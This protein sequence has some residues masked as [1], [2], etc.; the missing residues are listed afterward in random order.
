MGKSL[1]EV[2]YYSFC[3][4]IQVFSSISNEWKFDFSIDRRTR[5]TK[6]ASSII[7]N[8]QWGNPVDFCCVRTNKNN[9]ISRRCLVIAF[10]AFIR[11]WCLRSV[12][13]SQNAIET[14]LLLCCVLETISTGFLC[15]SLLTLATFFFF[16]F[17]FQLVLTIVPSSIIIV[18]DLRIPRFLIAFFL[19][20]FVFTFWH[21]GQGCDSVLTWECGNGECI[22]IT[23]RCNGIT[24]CSDGSDET[25]LDCIS[26]QCPETK[27]RCAYGACVEKS[28]ECN[29]MRDCADNSDELSPRCLTNIDEMLRGNC[30]VDFF[31][32]KS[33][34]CIPLDS[35][36]DGKAECRDRSDESVESCASTCC[37]P[38]GFR[39][40][41]GGCVDEKV[42][43]DGTFDCADES[44]ENYLLCGY[45]KGGRPPTTTTT[46]S[47]P[48]PLFN[49]DVVYYPDSFSNLPAGNVFAR[50]S[51]SSRLNV[52]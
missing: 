43:C 1:L 20:F 32:C 18:A 41:Y 14:K 15:L 23:E 16:T 25:V 28:A 11:R 39:C 29:G 48:A 10:T 27:F 2:I 9:L 33:G 34:E 49:K 13:A 17:F 47:T 31:Q 5:R 21:T 50:A 38:F 8:Q 35:A 12:S 40:G 3:Y 26:F 45:P 22:G 4:Q 7:A 24:D 19:F 51:F 44:D 6:F 52:D 37:P 46:T 30:S 36:C 42:R